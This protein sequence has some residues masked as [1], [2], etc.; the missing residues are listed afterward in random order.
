MA[1]RP[2]MN[3][4]P[5]LPKIT[6]K[7][8]LEISIDDEPSGR[9]VIG[10]F[11][12]VVPRTA[13]NFKRLCACD[14]GKGKLSGIDLCYKNTPIHRI[15]PNFMIQGGDFTHHDG[16]GGESIYGGKFDDESFEVLHNKINLVSMANAGTDTNGSQFFINTVKTSWLDGQHV[17]FGMI[18]EGK[19]LISK[20]ETLGT[21][22][23]K[24]RQKVMIT[25]SGVL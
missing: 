5:E 11:G 23:G 6:D 8:F 10:L 22:S 2:L 1:E 4:K 16:V 14:A 17:V 24:T 9:I 20:L 21:N 3:P 18:L 19:D 13:E 7:V 25:N 15:I 12:E